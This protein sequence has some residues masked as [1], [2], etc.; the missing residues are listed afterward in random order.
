[1]GQRA[2][3]KRREGGREGGREGEGKTWRGGSYKTQASNKRDMV[4]G[5]HRRQKTYHTVWPDVG[6]P[7]LFPLLGYE[8]ARRNA[9][10]EKPKGSLPVRG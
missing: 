1:M 8:S 7:H 10:R 4:S 5:I 6:L 9:K 3:K 2:N